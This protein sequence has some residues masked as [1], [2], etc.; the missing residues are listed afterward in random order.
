[1]TIEVFRIGQICRIILSV[2][3][4]RMPVK[5]QLIHKYTQLRFGLIIIHK[6]TTFALSIKQL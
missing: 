2:D 1:M 6:K 5:Y 4:W 3:V